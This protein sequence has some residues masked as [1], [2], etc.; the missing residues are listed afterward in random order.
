MLKN[1]K[2]LLIIFV[3]LFASSLF[4]SEYSYTWVNYKGRKVKQWHISNEKYLQ[5]RQVAI[6]SKKRIAPQKKSI[7]LAKTS[8]VEEKHFRWHS[9]IQTSS[10]RTSVDYGIANL[11]ATD[12][13]NQSEAVIYSDSYTGVNLKWRFGANRWNHFLNSRFEKI[14]FN[15]GDQ[16]I[17]DPETTL[18][19]VKVGSLYGSRFRFGGFF[20]Y[21]QYPFLVINNNNYAIETAPLPSFGLKMEGDLVDGPKWSLGYDLGA[22]YIMAGKTGNTSIN[23]GYK[24]GGSL[25]AVQKFTHFQLLVDL[26]FDYRSQKTTDVELGQLDFRTGVGFKFNF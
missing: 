5:K 7:Q 24:T 22:E 2:L 3:S 9:P 11:N 15:Q 20:Q 18:F 10:L 8:P 23:S 12:N 25:E 19:G 21:R 16:T 4:G 6:S 13:I 17:E 26:G 1:S 14:S